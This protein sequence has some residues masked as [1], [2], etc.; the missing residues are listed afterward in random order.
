MSKA[1]IHTILLTAVGTFL[2]NIAYTAY[3]SRKTAA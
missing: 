1:L 2:G 3:V